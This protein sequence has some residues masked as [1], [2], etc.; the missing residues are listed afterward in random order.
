MHKNIKE[1][2]GSKGIGHTCNKDY[3]CSSKTCRCDSGKKDQNG[4]CTMDNNGSADGKC[5]GS[6]L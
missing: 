2:F 4:Y 1:P 5:E 6:E 3:N